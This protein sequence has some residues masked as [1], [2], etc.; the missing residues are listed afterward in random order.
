MRIIKHLAE[1]IQDEVSGAEEYAK[2]AL[3]Y[4]LT[5][6]ELSKLYLELAKTEYSHVQKLHE[7]AVRKIKEA[8]ERGVE[9]PQ[10]MINRWDEIHSQM[11]EQMAQAKTYI[12][13]YR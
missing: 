12:D 11:I 10:A 2:D 8:E 4:Q 9:P 3:E 6:P 1:Q 13:M 5:D 7:Q